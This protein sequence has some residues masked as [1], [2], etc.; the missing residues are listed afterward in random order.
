MSTDTKNPSD[1]TKVGQME[2]IVEQVRNLEASPL[3]DYRVENDYL[4][5][6]GEGDLNA[7]IMFIGEAPGKRE[8]QTGQPFV[9]RAGRQL[10]A[11]LAS[12]GLD[13]QDVYIT[14]VL[15]DH[16]PGNRDPYVDE[17]DVYTPF[18]LHQ[19][20]VIKPD[21]VATLGRFAMRFM[22][23]HYELPQPG[24]TIGELHGEVLEAEASYGKVYVVP[25]YHPAAVFYN[26]DLEET[27]EEDF[28]VL[29]RFV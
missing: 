14:N 27:V 20:E 4:P 28:R 19:I 11:M 29:K 24:R 26:R 17:I 8:A 10:D 5:V 9:G 21:V 18:L 3:Y 23:E 12:I 16:P 13:R 1:T 22:V 2:E 6:I 15:K 7:R 25:L